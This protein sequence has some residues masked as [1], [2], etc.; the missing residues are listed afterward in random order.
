MNNQGVKKVLVAKNVMDG[1]NI[2]I[3]QKH[4]KKITEETIKNK[5]QKI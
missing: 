5:Y 2:N 3:I 4:T 1:H